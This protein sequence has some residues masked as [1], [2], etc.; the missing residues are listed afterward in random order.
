MAFRAY[1]KR[2]SLVDLLG[3]SVDGHR[4]DICAFAVVLTEGI[5]FVG[6]CHNGDRG[7]NASFRHVCGLRCEEVVEV[8]LCRQWDIYDAPGAGLFVIPASAD[9]V[10][11]GC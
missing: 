5:N 7:L 8:K 10:T 2:I 6:L 9:D 1:W 3:E 11:L 4:G